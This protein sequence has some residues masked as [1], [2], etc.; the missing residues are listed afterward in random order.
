MA[1][2]G[3]A[4]SPGE[5]ARRR[6]HVKFC[7]LTRAEDAAR[8]AALGARYL[9]VIFAGGPRLLSPERASALFASVPGTFGRVG[10]FGSQTPAEI[11]RVAGEVQLDAVQLHG[12]P[13][14]HAVDEVRA[15]F[16]GEVWAVVRTSGVEL[17]SGLGVL[18]SAADAVVLDAKVAGALGGTGVALDWEALAPRLDQV[19]G[20][21][22]LV[23]AGGLT[24]ANVARA[25]LLLAPDVVDV[26]SGVEQAPGVKDAARMSAFVEALG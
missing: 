24:P 25:A 14:P 5:P 12:D 23:L 19:R 1:G 7:G 20:G 10:V 9:G 2:P 3:G 11:A 26:S 13:S 8:G 21:G 4:R 16:A 22:R 15:R 18:F 17:P 6:P